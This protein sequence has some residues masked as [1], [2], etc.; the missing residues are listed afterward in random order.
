MTRSRRHVAVRDLGLTAAVLLV[1]YLIGSI[2]FAYII[3]KTVTGEDVTDARHRQRRLDER[4]AHDRLVGMVRGRGARRR[5][6]GPRARRCVGKAL[7]GGLALAVAR[8]AGVEPW[9][10]SLG[11]TRYR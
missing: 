2:P 6:Q 11:D 5:D 4:P 7:A 8:G 1:T 9:A 10:G 3:V